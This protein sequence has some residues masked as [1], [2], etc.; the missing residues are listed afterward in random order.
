MEKWEIKTISSK[1]SRKLHLKKTQTQS[2]ALE[3]IMK[4]VK[5]QNN[6]IVFNVKA[7]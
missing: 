3:L 4:K 7:M 1:T 6:N 5:S 2:K